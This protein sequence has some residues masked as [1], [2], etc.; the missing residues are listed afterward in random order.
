MSAS[1]R[2]FLHGASEF[3]TIA[4]TVVG[5]LIVIMNTYDS[6]STPNWNAQRSSDESNQR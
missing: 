3:L 5:A 4:S 6:T 2:A 1:F